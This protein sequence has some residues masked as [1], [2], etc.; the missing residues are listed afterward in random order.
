MMP[1]SS[2]CISLCTIKHIYISRTIIL[3]LNAVEH[4]VGV[5]QNIQLVD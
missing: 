2:W 4:S 1:T 5:S 3:D